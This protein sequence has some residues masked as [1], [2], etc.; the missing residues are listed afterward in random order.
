LTGDNEHGLKKGQITI[1]ASLEIQSTV[2]ELTAEDQYVAVASLDS[3]T[4]FDAVNVDL[5]LFSKAGGIFDN[6]Y[7]DNSN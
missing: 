1:T 5:L 2:A 6:S 3:S 4:A 7:Y